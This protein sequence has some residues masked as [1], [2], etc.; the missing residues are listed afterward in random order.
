MKIVLMVFFILM[1]SSCENNIDIKRGDT[2]VLTKG[3][4]KDC[5]FTIEYENFIGS[6]ECGDTT[7]LH[8]T[9]NKTEL[10]E[11]WGAVKK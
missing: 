2:F 8:W 1:L 9:T 11:K 10:F 5:K 7:Y 6:L 4:Y 3:F